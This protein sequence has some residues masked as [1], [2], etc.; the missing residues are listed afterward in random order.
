M[1][2]DL[3]HNYSRLKM[4]L[5]VSLLVAFT[6]CFLQFVDIFR[7][8]DSLILTFDPDKQYSA[9]PTVVMVLIILFHTIFP[10]IIIL[11]EG[12]IKGVIYTVVA[13]FFYAV[14]IH[15]YTSTFSLYIPLTAPLIGCMVSII[16]VLAWEHSFLTE[17]KDEIRKTLG[18]LVEPTV[19][20]FLLKNPDLLKQEGVRKTVTIMFADLRGFTKLCEVIAPEQLFAMLRD[21]FGKLISIVRTN[22]GTIDKL[23]GDSMMVVWGNPIPMEDHAEKAVEAAVE[24]Q[25]MMQS[26]KR[27]WQQK[28]GVDI[29]LGIGINT[30][31]VVAGTIGSEEF[32]DYTVLGC[33]VNLASRL[34]SVCPG[35]IIYV[36]GQT[37]SILNNTFEFEEID[38]LK[39]K[40][41][42]YMSKVY[43]VVT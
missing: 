22:G 8:F 9:L 5:V 11:E 43:K 41:N 33:G 32:C 7:N 2:L 42:F 10:G 30:D 18:S 39:D 36:S 37:Y 40:N 4:F 20:D 34:E 31:E 13:W 28:L 35:G 1:H 14:L 12:T 25:A 6:L 3:K 15:S 17:E 26:L 29:M 23:V 21:C 27:K 19:A 24:M 38:D 16:R